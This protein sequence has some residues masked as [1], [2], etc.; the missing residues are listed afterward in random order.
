MAHLWKN[1]AS[2]AWMSA[3]IPLFS[4]LEIPDQ[5][6][7]CIA[8]GKKKLIYPLWCLAR[9]RKYLQQFI[10]ILT[11]PHHLSPSL[12]HKRNQYTNPSKM[13]LQDIGPPSSRSSGFPNKAAILCPNNLSVNLLACHVAS[14]MSFDLVT[15]GLVSLP[16]LFAC[17]S[18]HL[19]TFSLSSD[20][21]H[22]T[23][24]NL[25]GLLATT[26]IFID[27]SHLLI[28]PFLSA[29]QIEPCN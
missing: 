17:G 15:L 21:S 10:I 29:L 27:S 4:S 24:L 16:S 12:F 14:S 18:S 23:Y 1:S 5:A 7:L 9:T 2:Y 3:K 6:H 25:M 20:Y 11:L 28:S 26:P 13:V 22:F 8:A 19:N